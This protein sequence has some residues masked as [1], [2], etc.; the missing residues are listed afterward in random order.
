[1]DD[2]DIK[3]IIKLNDVMERQFLIYV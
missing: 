3:L 1:M 2:I